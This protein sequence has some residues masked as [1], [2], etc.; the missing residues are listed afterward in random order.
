MSNK[1]Q[2]CLIGAKKLRAG[3]LAIENIGFRTRDNVVAFHKLLAMSKKSCL[4]C[5]GLL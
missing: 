3:F 4:V 5:C 2:T 1:N